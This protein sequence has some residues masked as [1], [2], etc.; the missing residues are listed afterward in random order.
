MN[1]SSKASSLGRTVLTTLGFLLIAAFFLQTE[2]RA[3]L[4]GALPFLFLLACPLLHMFMH[5]GHGSHGEGSAPPGG[6]QRPSDGHSAHGASAE[7][8]R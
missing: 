6:T 4:F 7:D 3:H 8:F 2:H 1:G 5:R